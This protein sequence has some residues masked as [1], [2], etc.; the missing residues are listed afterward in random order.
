MYKDYFHAI[1]RHH[2]PNFGKQM[3]SA[4]GLSPQPRGSAPCSEATSDL[5]MFVCV[6]VCVQCAACVCMCTV[7]SVCVCVHVYSVQRVCVHVYSV[8]CVC[9]HV[10]SVQHM[11]VCACV[12]CT[13]CV[14]VCICT[15]CMCGVC[16]CVHTPASHTTEDGCLSRCRCRK[17][18]CE[19]QKHLS[20]WSRGGRARPMGTGGA[21]PRA[22]HL[23]WGWHLVEMAETESVL[24]DSWR[25][26]PHALCRPTGH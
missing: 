6:C 24:H 20:G 14:C 23:G 22:A 16:V 19:M 11:C 21:A 7:Y 15:V 17:Q 26:C 5:C 9:V 13:A 8:Q 12:Q 4:P 3:I 18:H 25:C 1:V 10:Y 2:D